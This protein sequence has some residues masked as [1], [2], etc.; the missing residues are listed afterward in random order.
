MKPLALPREYSALRI[1]TKFQIF[2]LFWEPFDLPGFANPFESGSE[3][4]GKKSIFTLIFTGP[5]CK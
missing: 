2:F 3:S 4:L 5:L 1:F